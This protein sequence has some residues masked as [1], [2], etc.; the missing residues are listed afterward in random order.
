[1]PKNQTFSRLLLIK[2]KEIEEILTLE[3]EYL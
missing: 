3:I 2:T 1:M